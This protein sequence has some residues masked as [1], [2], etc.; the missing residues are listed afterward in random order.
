MPATLQEATN[1]E[2]IFQARGPYYF[3]PVHYD[4]ILKND[5]YGYQAFFN[6]EKSSQDVEAFVLPSSTKVQ[7]TVRT[8]TRNL[9]SGLLAWTT[10]TTSAE[11]RDQKQRCTPDSLSGRQL[12]GFYTREAQSTKPIRHIM[13]QPMPVELGRSHNFLPIDLAN[14]AGASSQANLWKTGRMDDRF[15]MLNTW[16]RKPGCNAW[17]EVT[18]MYC[19]GL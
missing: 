13:K 3:P 19:R 2:W 8:N 17:V 16:Y 15:E 7:R 5:V 6:G 10:N 9:P 14:L 18:H 12:T 11:V 1:K 4:T